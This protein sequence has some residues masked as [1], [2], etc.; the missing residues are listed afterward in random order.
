MHIRETQTQWKSKIFTRIQCLNHTNEKISVQVELLRVSLFVDYPF[1]SFTSLLTHWVRLLV[2]YKNFENI[3]KPKPRRELSYTLKNW[4][5][6]R[7][8]VYES[9][10]WPVVFWVSDLWN[11]D[12][13]MMAVH[14]I[15]LLYSLGPLYRNY[16]RYCY[17]K[18][19]LQIIWITD[20]KHFI[21]CEI[22]PCINWN[23]S[24]GMGWSGVRSIIIYLRSIKFK[25]K[26]ES[27][28][29]LG[30]FSGNIQ[31]KR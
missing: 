22:N 29:Y 23:S 26:M 11:S 6:D 20:D 13:R 28:I 8:T 15:I 1:A 18:M 14:R 19:T 3:C 12:L 30:L 31:D 4:S 10:I 27:K 24:C 25:R 2:F 9:Q 17:Y 16:G 21:F 7:P 5:G